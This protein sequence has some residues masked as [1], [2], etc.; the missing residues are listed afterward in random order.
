M[1]IMERRIQRLYDKL[2]TVNIKYPDLVQEVISKKKDKYNGF[3]HIVTEVEFENQ[4]NSIIESIATLSKKSKAN[5]TCELLD[6]FNKSKY[7]K[8]GLIS[9][10]SY[11]KRIGINAKPYL[12]ECLTDLN[13]ITKPTRRNKSYELTDEGHKYGNYLFTD[14]GEKYIGWNKALLDKKIH[15]FVSDI[16]KGLDFRLY[17]LTHIINLKSILNQGLKCHNDA[18]GYKDISNLEVN[19]RRERERKSFGSLHDYVPLYFNPRNA[20]LYQT[21]KQ[22]NDQIII[23]EINREIVKKDYTVFSQGNAARWDSSLTRCKIKVASFD[24]DMICDR[25]WAKIGSGV[26]DVKQKS[27]MMSECLIF[28]SISSSYINRIHCKN[29]S[30]ANKVSE[31]I[32]ENIQEVQIS[33]QLYF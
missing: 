14:N 4:I 17:H 28:E 33:P 7:E 12:F 8:Q 15:P 16:V 21:C 30:T 5:I 23:L 32:E 25:T 3:F 18:S 19:E 2:E 9:T 26:V 13:L 27:M 29:F 1:T 6:G 20:M 31:F 10:T 11:G 22:F 24:W